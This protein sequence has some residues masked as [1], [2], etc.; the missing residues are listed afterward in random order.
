MNT[1]LW[2]A[3]FQMWNSLGELFF[4]FELFHIVTFFTF[5]GMLMSL[6]FG[7]MIWEISGRE[8]T[9]L[10]TIG[11]YFLYFLLFLGVFYVI[12][13]L[14]KV[15]LFIVESCESMME[16]IESAMRKLKHDH[17]K[18][19]EEYKHILKKENNNNEH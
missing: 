8:T 18:I 12:A 11:K 17:A 2:L 13:I 7:A 1:K 16:G 9:F 4:K 10:L 14:T 19:N 6:F 5:V 3:R 15:P